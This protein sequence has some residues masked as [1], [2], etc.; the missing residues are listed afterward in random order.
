M[1]V[2]FTLQERINIVKKYYATNNAAEAGRM[3]STH[4]RSRSTVLRLIKKFETTGS[5]KDEQ[6]NGRPN[7]YK[8]EEFQA[9]ALREINDN[10]LTSTRRI[11]CQLADRS[12]FHTSFECVH[13][14]HGRTDEKLTD[15]A[16]D[17]LRNQMPSTTE[18]DMYGNRI[19]Y[20]VW[21]WQLLVLIAM[22][23]P[24][25][26]DSHGFRELSW[27]IQEHFIEFSIDENCPIG[28]E[29]GTV[30]VSAL[31]EIQPTAQSQVGSD[32]MGLTY[33]LG[34]PS[35][36]F[37]LNEFSGQITTKA[38]VDA[39][40]LCAQVD[41]QD[42]DRQQSTSFSTNRTMANRTVTNAGYLDRISCSPNDQVS[43]HLDISAVMPDASLHAVHRA[44]I[45]VHDVNDNWPKFDQ[46]RWHRR[47]R[48]AL[49]RKGRRLEL[50]KARDVDLLSENSRIYYRLESMEKVASSGPNLQGIPFRLDVSPSG[51]P[52]LILTEDLDAETKERYRFTLVAHSSAPPWTPGT[53]SW[54]SDEDKRKHF[55]PSNS[56]RTESRLEIDI[57]V[58]D[59]NDNE[60]AFSAS[61]YNV[62]VTEDTPPGTV[63]F[64]IAAYDSDSSAN[65]TYS[66]GT[67]EEIAV[68]SAAF[69][70]E[71]DG[72]I[73][74][75]T[76]LDYEHRHEYSLP[77]EVSD[78]EFDAQTFLHVHVEDVNDEPPEFEINPKQLVA[79]ENAPVG[80]LIGRIRVLDPDGPAI[81]G[82]IKC[83]E[84]ADAAQQQVLSLHPDPRQSPT[85]R[86]YD[87]K[88]RIL[89]DRETMFTPLPGRLL[90]YL[91]CSD[92]NDIQPSN[93]TSIR[94]TSTMTATLTIRDVNDHPPVFTS[95]VYH[96]SIYE[97]NAVG[98]KIVQV[99]IKTKPPQF[100]SDSFVDALNEIQPEFVPLLMQLK[101]SEVE[102]T[103][104]D[105]GGNAQ[106]IYSLL[107]RTNFKLDSL[108]GWVTANMEFDRE[109][110]DSY[111]VTVI[112]TDQGNPRLSSSALLNLTVLDANDHRPILLPCELDQTDFD[113]DTAETGQVPQ[114]NLFVVRENSPVYTYLGKVL[115]LDNDVGLNA[116]LKFEL[117][118]GPVT[119]HIERFKLF[120]NG[121]LYTTARLDREEKDQYLLTVRVSDRSPRE[122]LSSTG[123]ISVIVQDENDNAPKLVEPSQLLPCDLYPHTMVDPIW[124]QYSPSGQADRYS[125]AESS[126]L[127]KLTS[128]EE[129][130]NIPHDHGQW[131]EIKRR[132]S[133]TFS[134][135]EKPGFEVTHL[136]AEDPDTGENGRILYEIREFFHFESTDT[137]E[138]PSP[139]LLT[140]KPEYGNVILNRLMST[141]DLGYHYFKVFASDNGR[142]VKKVD[143]KILII[144]VE[145]VP[146]KEGK[147][148]Y[149]LSS[150]Y[151]SSN[152]TAF[153][154]WNTDGKKSTLTVIVLVTLASL[155]AAVLVTAIICIT[156]S[157]FRRRRAFSA[158]RGRHHQTQYPNLPSEI[159][160]TGNGSI[161]F[162]GRASVSEETNNCGT[163]SCGLQ[164]GLYTHSGGGLS[165]PVFLEDWNTSFN[166]Y[167]HTSLL[168]PQ[169]QP[170]TSSLASCEKSGV[171]S[172]TQS[173]AVNYL[174]GNNDYWR[175]HN[176]WDSRDDREPS[177]LTAAYNCGLLNPG[178][179]KRPT[180]QEDNQEGAG[181]PFCLPDA[182]EASGFGGQIV[183]TNL[184]LRCAEFG[185]TSAFESATDERTSD[186]GQGASEEEYHLGQ[187]T[188]NAMCRNPDNDTP[189]CNNAAANIEPVASNV[190]PD[191]LKS[192]R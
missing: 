99:T 157:C 57:E 67:S 145:N 105:E 186:S 140:V 168:Q 103:D 128:Y 19:G 26:A 33:R 55:T 61:S 80:K 138:I 175:P 125:Q 187:M 32:P 153:T 146:A 58:I 24:N 64:R 158:T 155:V 45:R 102:A 42:I 87:L 179:I 189:T 154:M 132:P 35:S 72:Q 135:H 134:V 183:T 34:S 8:N 40:A 136:K 152:T 54:S 126:E 18:R 143:Q 184:G 190:Q 92:G 120:K 70:V 176:S 47:L 86:V 108:T 22:M 6:R 36:L 78:G 124:P 144:L 15:P 25:T 89:L 49:Y 74:L 115:A 104:A 7:L 133:I 38:E 73:K 114:H 94:H 39:E 141:R 13:Q 174:T 131:N 3:T 149:G 177:S 20:N 147:K 28:T 69:I 159:P 60:P 76:S 83:S 169:F 27:N 88:T 98:D 66:M 181:L 46:V 167:G 9:T 17:R 173:P 4:S 71:G 191:R 137:S 122:P 37:T 150:D 10:N 119:L 107:D 109:R 127:D 23:V 170:N 172:Y 41:S 51:Q 75:R 68:M 16:V 14:R 12:D 81:N 162:G 192:D 116:D 29:I 164:S 100:V 156:C 5:V 96:V 142:A 84:P 123:V 11:A 56:Q 95:P 30:S 97:N 50:P 110:R 185:R 161:C 48:E 165:P 160:E 44:L 82:R 182:Y 52:G 117:V 2:R 130:K 113:P 166:E 171:F 112:A 178:F 93:G 91:I 31:P 118:E 79:D 1:A 62:S 21:T 139:P 53:S 59:M 111:Q 180:G 85:S 188:S 106:I 43:I 101:T 148:N 65:L 63:I 163:L 151:Y 129:H 121:S 77:I 90:V